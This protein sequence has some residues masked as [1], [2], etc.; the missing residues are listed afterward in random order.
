MLDHVQQVG[1]HFLR[2]VQRRVASVVFGH[3]PDGTDVGFLGACS[4]AA[5]HHRV[6]G[7]VQRQS[8]AATRL[9]VV[10]LGRPVKFRSTSM[11]SAALIRD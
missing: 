2:C 11:R 10:A 7:L 4:K 1:L 6:S 3:A 9:R 5:L 8:Q